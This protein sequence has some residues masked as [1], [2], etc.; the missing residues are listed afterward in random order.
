MLKNVD[1][2]LTGSVLKLLDD[3]G[4]GDVL[5]L[6]DRN[7]PAYRYKVP[8]IDFRGSDTA[9]VGKALLSVFPLDGFVD[10]PVHRMEIDGAPNEV[11]S[12]TAELQQIANAEEGSE[13]VIAPV[14]RFAFYDLAKQAY[15]F[16]QTGETVPYSCYL[17]RKGVV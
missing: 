14:E 17:L 11:S 1:P 8:V 9:S 5:G 6:V 12:A 15:A 3:M 7:F 10:E 4:H 2:L 16:V 13:V